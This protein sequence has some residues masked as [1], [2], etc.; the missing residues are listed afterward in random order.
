MDKYEW[1]Q[2][3]RDGFPALWVFVG[4]WTASALQFIVGIFF[5][6]YDGLVGKERKSE[7]K[8][9]PMLKF[10]FFIT[11]SASIIFT[12]ILYTVII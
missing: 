4:L 5:A 10:Q 6:F 2:Y 7:L 1:F 11:V 9:N 3:F 12:F 8:I